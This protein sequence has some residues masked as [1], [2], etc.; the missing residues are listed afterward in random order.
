LSTRTCPPPE[1]SEQQQPGGTHTL[2]WEALSDALGLTTDELYAELN[3]S[4]TLAE[5]HQEM[6]W[7]RLVW[8]RRL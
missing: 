1:R 3:S 4:K 6:V 7:T 5:L 8:L 2:A